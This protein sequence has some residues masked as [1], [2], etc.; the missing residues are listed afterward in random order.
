MVTLIE[1]K[2]KSYLKSDLVIGNFSY[3]D[4]HDPLC[5]DGGD[6]DVPVFHLLTHYLSDGADDPL[7]KLQEQLQ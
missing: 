2:R 3:Q 6:D 7:Q 5:R 4:D 1:I